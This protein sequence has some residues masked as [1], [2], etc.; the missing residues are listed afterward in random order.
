VE[1]ALRSNTGDSARL[2]GALSAGGVALDVALDAAGAAA[3]LGSAATGFAGV[4]SIG[5]ALAAAG[6][7]FIRASV[8]GE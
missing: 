6:R 4:A 8:G 5:G 7:A 2:G 3:A 1:G